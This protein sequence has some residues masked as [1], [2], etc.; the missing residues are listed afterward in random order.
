VIPLDAILMLVGRLDDEPG[1]E[2][3][4]QRF[5]RFLH[6][7]V[8]HVGALRALID[9]AQNVPGEQHQRALKDLV[10]TLGRFLGFET[11]YGVYQHAEGGL[12]DDGL[13]RSRSRLQVVLD[14]RSDQAEA[15]VDSLLR[16]GAALAD[17]SGKGGAK[18]CG[19]C[20]VT[21]LFGARKK[22]EKSLTWA[23]LDFPVAVVALG[24][25]VGL[26]ELVAAGRLAHDDVVR[27]LDASMP[28]E[29]VVDLMERAMG[30]QERAPEP[31]PAVF[32]P[33]AVP[34]G[35]EPAFWLATLAGDLDAAPEEFLRL[36]VG[37]RHLFGIPDT[38]PATQTARAGD[39]ICFHIPGKGVVGH[40]RVQ[41]L[42]NGHVAIR[43]PHR[44]RQLVHLDALAL[45]LEAPVPLDPD[46]QLRLRTT[47]ARATRPSSS[48]VRISPESFST[49]ARVSRPGAASN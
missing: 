34:A 22:I 37:R 43:S 36:V 32:V 13:W 11:T 28:V 23:K 30:G 49:F 31:L 42:A 6:D 25:L 45:H 3:S 20:V 19:L 47:G 46:T 18:T 26:A 12:K 2:A 48:L 7:H 29:F 40:A 24:S 35:D 4:R 16:S 17:G 44:F 9:G 14:I 33:A 27:M 21:P 1:F 15:D 8:T 5:R 10:V 38:G 41:S 39:S